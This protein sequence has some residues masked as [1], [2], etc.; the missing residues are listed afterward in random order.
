[1]K[2]LFAMCRR[3]GPVH[4]RGVCV[5]P[6]TKPCEWYGL[7]ASAAPDHP[8]DSVIWRVGPLKGQRSRDSHS[9]FSAGRGCSAEV[10]TT[11]PSLPI[12]LEWH[13]GENERETGRGADVHEQIRLG[14]FSS[15]LHQL[16]TRFWDPCKAVLLTVVL[17]NQSLN[18][19]IIGSHMNLS[20]SLTKVTNESISK[21]GKICCSA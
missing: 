19:I 10:Y 21:G 12:S 9:C 4:R 17:I 6:A 3:R 1:M 2:A 11:A 15:L 14:T 16:E 13:L 8:R 20:R 5:R 18:F 7:H